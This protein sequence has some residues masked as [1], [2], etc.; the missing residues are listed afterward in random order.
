[1][2]I[3]GTCQAFQVNTSMFVHVIR[4]PRGSQE[5]AKSVLRE[6]YCIMMPVLCMPILN[7][8]PS[9]C[10]FLSLFS[11]CMIMIVLCD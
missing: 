5:D 11:K 8:Y 4:G 2:N 1:M 7:V 10:I 9:E 3:A 6:P